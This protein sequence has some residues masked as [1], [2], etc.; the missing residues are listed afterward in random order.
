MKL[1]ARVGETD[2]EIVVERHDATFRVT[3]DGQTFDVDARS[4]TGDF[5]TILMRGRSYWVSA[6]AEGDS[7]LVRHGAAVQRVTL[8]DPSRRARQGGLAAGRGPAAVTT[9]MPGKVVRVLVA[10]GDVVQPGQGVVVVEAMKMENEITAPKA[11][12]VTQVLVE[13]GRAVEG[14]ATLVVVE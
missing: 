12:K 2:H 8:T 9:L 11:G 7:Y 5:Y 10:V 14:G 6:E 13:A 4:L 1:N 3:V